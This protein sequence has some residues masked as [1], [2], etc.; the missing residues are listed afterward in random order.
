MKKWL[1]F[2]P[3]WTVVQLIRLLPLFAARRV[4]DMLAWGLYRMPGLRQGL[5]RENLERAFPDWEP[6]KRR[7]IAKDC[8]RF[9]VRA[10]VEW[11]KFESVFEREDIH[12]EELEKLDSY[13]EEGALLVTG[14][15]GYWELLGGLIAERYGGIYVYAD[16]QSNPYSQSLIDDIRARMNVTTGAGM[17]GIRGLNRQL[18]AGGFA[19]FV[20][21]QRPRGKPAVVDFF[22]H[23]VKATRIPAVVARRTGAAVVPAFA[24]R[25]SEGQI[26]IKIEEPLAASRDGLAAGE[27]N[28][29]LAQYNRILEEYISRYPEQYFWLH[30]RWKGTEKISAADSSPPA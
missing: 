22:A 8:Y 11:L 15:L 14:H 29:L 16:V 20:A 23:P 27:E 10:G 1:E 9:F 5:V 6:K 17:E 30:N 28:K 21:D 18:E 26:K 2:V 4:A 7:R 19:G 12:L 24:L 25:S 13:A 3:I